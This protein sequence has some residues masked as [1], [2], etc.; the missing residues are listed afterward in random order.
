IG[1]VGNAVFSGRDNRMVGVLDGEDVEGRN[2]I[3]GIY[4]SG[5]IKAK[6]RD[7]NFTYD[8]AKVM[9]SI[10][11]EDPD[12]NNLKF[13][14]NIKVEGDIS[15]IFEQVDLFQPQILQEL[16]SLIEAEMIRLT[17]RTVMKCQKEYETDVIGLSAR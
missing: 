5:G 1:I 16:E 13:T 14:I 11:V 2:L 15:E 10:D 6:F 8:I 4:T 3:T 12:P 7:A 9:S 17:E